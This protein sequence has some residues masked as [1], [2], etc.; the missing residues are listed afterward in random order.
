MWKVIGVKRDQLLVERKLI[1]YCDLCLSGKSK[2]GRIGLRDS[3]RWLDCVDAMLNSSYTQVS[4]L[5]RKAC[6]SV[7]KAYIGTG[8]TKSDR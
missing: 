4:A 6:P 7:G 5:A 2:S 8:L 1:N 3:M